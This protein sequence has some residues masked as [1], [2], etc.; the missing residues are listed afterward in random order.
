MREAA[1]RSNLSPPSDWHHHHHHQTND[2]A[3][4]SYQLT[5]K[6][7]CWRDGFGLYP[8][9]PADCTLKPR[10]YSEIPDRWKFSFL[11]VGGKDLFLFDPLFFFSIKDL[12]DL[13]FSSSGHQHYLYEAIDISSPLTLSGEE[14]LLD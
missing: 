12:G 1:I 7:T 8:A 3:Q 10:E 11:G 13:F 14:E 2:L 4:S 6:R 5:T 9:P